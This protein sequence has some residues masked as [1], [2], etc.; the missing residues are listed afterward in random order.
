MEKKLL[1]LIVLFFIGMSSYAQ[2]LWEENFESYAVNTGIT[3]I[4]GN[5]VGDYPLS[6]PFTIDATDTSFNDSANDYIIAST[7]EFLLRDLDGEAIVTFNPV[8]ISSQTGDLTITFGRVDFNMRSSTSDWDTNAYIDILY[9]LD[10]GVT[11]TLFADHMGQGSIEH[12]FITPASLATGSDFNTS[13][14]ETIM[15]GAATSIILQIK[16]FNTGAN[17]EFEIDD[18]DIS[19][20]A[21]SLWSDDFASYTDP[22]GVIGTGSEDFQNSGDYP[23]GVTKWTLSTFSNNQLEGSED[24][25]FVTSASENGTKVYKLNDVNE[26][27]T[28]QSQA[29]SISGESQVTFG[30]DITFGETTY[31]SG[32]YVDVFYSTN[33]GATYTLVQDDGSGN[34]FGGLNITA[35]YNTPSTKNVQFSETLNGLAA[36]ELVLR[37]VARNNNSSEDYEIDNIEVVAGSTLSNKSNK[38]SEINLYPNP[39]TDNMLYINSVLSREILD[40]DLYDVTG[41]NVLSAKLSNSVNV[42]NINDLNKGVYMV[43][44]TQAK[45]TII[46]KI[47]VK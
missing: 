45:N 14:T 22:S 15:P 34:T 32:D 6:T 24:Y 44:L 7:G 11:Y 39:V 33:G 5:S 17:E 36:S 46:K 3:G 8:D 42:L 18:L 27:I 47:V 4:D 26:A 31:E 29:I 19:R 10:N 12:T 16:A 20:N 37:I 9:S 2:I 35:N 38:L 30:F 21:V 43:K 40:V 28:F 25:A 1:N 13:F 41:K 23:S